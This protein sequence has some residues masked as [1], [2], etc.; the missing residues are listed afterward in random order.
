MTAA[1]IQHLVADLIVFIVGSTGY[2]NTSAPPPIAPIARPVLEQR[3]CGRPCPVYALFD[4]GEGI[5]VDDSL[6]LVGDTAAQSVLL[7]E[8]VHY[9]QW[10]ASGRRARNCEEWMAREREAYRIQFA[11]LLSR[12]YVWTNTVLPRPNLAL[13]RCRAEPIQAWGD[14]GPHLKDALAPGV[15]GPRAEP[16]ISHRH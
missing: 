7:H 13:L 15:A 11:W 8:L 10:A 2:A 6:D 4:P 14:P 9:L 12:D 1:A 3:V 5:L 16:G